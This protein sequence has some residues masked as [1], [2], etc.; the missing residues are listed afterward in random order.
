MKKTLVIHPFLFAVYPV[1]FLFTGNMMF[2]P[3]KIMFLPLITIIC[4][5]LLLW[6]LLNRSLKNSKKTGLLISLF[7]IVFFSYGR[8]YMLLNHSYFLRYNEYVGII[9]YFTLIGP[10]ILLAHVFINTRRNLDILT[11]YLN[12]VAAFV[13]ILSLINIGVYYLRVWNVWGNK[14]T[15]NIEANP[16]NSNKTASR[17]NIYYIIL[18]G[19]GRADILQEIYHHDN[20]EFLDYL[21][22]KGFYIANKSRA[23]YIQTSLSLASSLNFSYV[24]TLFDKIDTKSN[25]R[26]P[27]KEKIEYNK[28]FRFFK[29]N[30]YDIITYPSVSEYAGFED[31]GKYTG[32]KDIDVI[33]ILPN[34]VNI[35]PA[36]AEGLNLDEFRLALLNTTFFTLFLRNFSNN[37]GFDWHRERILFTLSR[38]GDESG[39]KSPFFV[40]AHILIP[41]PPFLFGPQGERTNYDKPYS[42]DDANYFIRNNETTRKSYRKGYINQIKFANREIK[43]IIDKILSNSA[44]EPIIILQG[45]HGPGS[46]L[47][48]HDMTRS[49]L[50]ERMSILNA[51]YLPGNGVKKLYNTITPV[52]T[53]RIISNHYFG[54][55][56]EILKDESY[57]S[58][59]SYPYNFIKHKENK[60]IQV[61][62]LQ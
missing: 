41:H 1:L 44:T 53:F 8:L 47:I 15:R 14:S 48:W 30:G 11:S 5:T 34:K 37:A 31:V 60:P 22:N 25:Y 18:D 36:I 40:F 32:F 39:F 58:T 55:N 3:P 62:T 38:L 46:M 42:M 59:W 50:D 12:K 6:F 21:S 16:I 4:F 52:N 45:D 43:K 57:A 54:T 13:V 27:L 7:I 56:F 29:Q 2:F 51:Y 20:S 26:I 28:V 33:R 9:L 24:E 61:T 35:N 49:Y 10:C 17:P 19:Y 23:N